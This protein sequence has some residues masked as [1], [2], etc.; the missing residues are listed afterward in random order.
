[1]PDADGT[2]V[3]IFQSSKLGGSYCIMDA[4]VY[5]FKQQVCPV[6][7]HFL[8]SD[9]K[10]TYSITFKYVSESKSLC[11]VHIRLKKSTTRICFLEKETLKTPQF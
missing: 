7:Y 8:M 11:K 3:R 9:K 2:H 4:T 5:F 1:M 10:L 6:P